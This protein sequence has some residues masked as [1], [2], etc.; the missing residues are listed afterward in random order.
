MNTVLH[1]SAYITLLCKQ[2]LQ[3]IDRNETFRQSFQRCWSGDFWLIFKKA[4]T[5]DIY[6]NWNLQMLIDLL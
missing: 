1:K 4:A 2:A 5:K 6:Y 3:N